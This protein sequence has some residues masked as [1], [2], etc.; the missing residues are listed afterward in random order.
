MADDEVGTTIITRIEML[1]GRFDRL[2][3]A[4]TGEELVRAQQLLSKTEHAL[5]RV[6]TMPFDDNAAPLFDQLRLAKR[7]RQIGRADLLIASIALAN[8]AILVTRNLR[9][10]RRIPNLQVVNWLD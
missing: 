8:R 5:G 6:M 2:L 7:T 4:A 9:D 1:R 10:F 3:K